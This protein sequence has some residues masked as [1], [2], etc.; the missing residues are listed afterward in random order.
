MTYEDGELRYVKLGR[1]E[2][3]RRL[4]VAVRDRIWRTISPRLENARIDAH[5]DT[6]IIEFDAHHVEDEIDFFWRGSIVG[7]SLGKISFLMDG[8]A[9]STFWRGRIGFCILHPMRECAGAR[10]RVEQDGVGTI[11]GTFPLDIDPHAPF[12]DMTAIAHEVEDGV[13]AEL[14]FTGDLFE[15]EDQRNWTDASFKTF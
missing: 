13:W 5:D 3:V 10:V 12:L 7:D 14:R 1:R 15:M 4:Y 11:T 9:R 8:H 2:V 6:F